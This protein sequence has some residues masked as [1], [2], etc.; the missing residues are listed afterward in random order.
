MSDCAYLLELLEQ[1]P[2]TNQA[3][4]AQS[5]RD[6]GCGMVVNSRVSELR[7]R[8]HQIHSERVGRDRGGRE[9]WVYRLLREPVQLSLEAVA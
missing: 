7:R 8:G 5:Q 2:V 9:V 6:R 1:G 4:L 3:I